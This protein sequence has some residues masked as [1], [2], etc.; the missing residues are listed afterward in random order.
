MATVDHNVPTTD[1]SLPIVDE[2]AL[3]QIEAME[4]NSAE[5]GVEFHGLNDPGQGIVHVIGPEQGYTQPGMV[6]V[7]G[8]SHTSTHG[9]FG[10]LAFG[11]GSSQVEHVLALQ[12]IPQAPSPVMQVR[13]EGTLGRGV[14]PKDLIL[15]VIGEIGIDGATGHVIEYTGSAIRGLSMEGRMTVCNMSIEGGGARRHDRPRRDHLRLSGRQT[16]RSPGPRTSPTPSSGGASSPATRARPSTARS[17]STPRHWRLMSR[18]A[19]T[20][21][22]RRR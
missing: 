7:C 8:D 6:I 5:F 13:V 16:A 2:M 1:R 19:P 3:A 11:I 9:A 21:A 12:C 17:R 15:A 10:A 22:C 20:P 14:T 18:G 4:R